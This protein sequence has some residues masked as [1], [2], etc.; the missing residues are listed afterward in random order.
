MADPVVVHGDLQAT[1]ILAGH[2]GTW[3]ID[4][5]LIALAPRWWDLA[6]LAMFAER[7]DTAG[8]WSAALPTLQEEYC[9]VD[10]AALEAW[11]TYALIATTAGC[12][13]KRDV[14]PELGAEAHDRL[15]WWASDPAA[16]T[17]RFL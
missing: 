9:Q 17:W 10:T 15:R 7:F 14:R 2:D 3:L 12:I 4:F 11:T 6:K 16:P 8:W 13:A 5:E 1:N